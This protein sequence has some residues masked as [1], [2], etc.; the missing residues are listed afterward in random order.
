MGQ[1]GTEDMLRFLSACRQEEVSGRPGPNVV[2]LSGPARRRLTPAS[3]NLR[4]AAVTG[5]YEYLQMRDRQRGPRSPRGSRAPGP[6][7]EAHR[8]VGTHQTTSNAAVPP[9]IADRAPLAAGTDPTG[10]PGPVGKLAHHPGL[11][12]PD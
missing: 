9:A 7:P 12:T 6:L 5:W 8:P 4:L 2:D 10:G 3:I 11:A 1:V